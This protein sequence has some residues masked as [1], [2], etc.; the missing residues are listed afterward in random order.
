MISGFSTSGH[1]YGFYNLIDVRNLIQ[2]D[3]SLCICL[4]VCTGRLLA[5]ICQHYQPVNVLKFTDDGTY[6]LS[7]G[8]DNRVLVWNFGRLSIFETITMHMHAY[9]LLT[10]KLS[11]IH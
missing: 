9:C 10:T 3:Q 11:L 7:G 5:V 2:N 1:I 4:Q 8:D 6:L